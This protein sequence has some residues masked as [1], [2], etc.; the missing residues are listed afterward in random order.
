MISKILL[1]AQTL[2]LLRHWSLFWM[3][4]PCSVRIAAHLNDIEL[5]RRKTQIGTR[6][7]SVRIL[8]RRGSHWHFLNPSLTPFHIRVIGMRVLPGAHALNRCFIN[9]NEPRG[10]EPLSFTQ[11]IDPLLYIFIDE[12]NQIISLLYLTVHICGQIVE[13]LPHNLLD[14]KSQHFEGQ[15][16]LIVRVN[17]K[18]HNLL[19]I[20]N[21]DLVV[22]PEWCKSLG[23]LFFWSEFLWSDV[24]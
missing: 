15:R 6:G 18:F 21:I 9:I 22:L 1:P 12:R 24:F 13:V 19:Q 16:F 10:P 14:I 20:L 5:F 4:L 3:T 7:I 2:R 11:E 8:S 17:N 23:E